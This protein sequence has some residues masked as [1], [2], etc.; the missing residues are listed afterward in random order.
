MSLDDL[1]Q[2]PFFQR[3]GDLL[4]RRVPPDEVPYALFEG[5]VPTESQ[6]RRII[7]L[8]Y[9]L[10]LL[11][12]PLGHVEFLR[13][14]VGLRR[15]S[16]IDAGVDTTAISSLTGLR[17][18]DIMMGQPTRTE[19][20]QLP[21]LES[22]FGSLKGFESV[23]DAPAVTRIEV[24][25]VNQGSLP[26]VP[27]QLQSLTLMSASKTSSLVAE[28]SDVEPALQTLWVHNA[29]SFDVGSLRAF[30]HLKD[31]TFE[32]V[33][34]LTGLAH[35]DALNLTHLTLEKCRSVDDIEVLRRCP[36]ERLTVVG[37]LARSIG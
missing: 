2:L 21:Q 32:S 15:L 14:N 8:G 17:E 5:T 13:H 30:P 12:N 25:S 6:L 20:S 23:F 22:Y 27:P 9:G 31:V 3:E 11:A 4:V 1:L 24:H 19:L 18:L 37:P 36:T 7:D 10:A 29:R 26:A 16:V 33:R 34:E 28:P 35:L